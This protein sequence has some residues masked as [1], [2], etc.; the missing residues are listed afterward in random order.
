MW[1]L[2]MTGSSALKASCNKRRE[3]ASDLEALAAAPNKAVPA[4]SVV[5]GMIPYSRRTSGAF[6]LFTA[7][8][9]F[10]ACDDITYWTLGDHPRTL[11]DLGAFGSRTS[12]IT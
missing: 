1:I 5:P 11:R 2:V 10:T 6:R 3:R 8:A 4:P 12:S 9:R 7:G